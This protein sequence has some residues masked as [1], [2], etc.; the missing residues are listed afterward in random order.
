MHRA[1][2]EV[3]AP[4]PPTGHASALILLRIGDWRVIYEPTDE[5][6][7]LAVED[8]RHRREAYR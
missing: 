4:A 6:R 1:A 8:V 7:I 5:V 3:N 2:A